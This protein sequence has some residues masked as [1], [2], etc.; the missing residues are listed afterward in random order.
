MNQYTKKRKMNI[1]NRAMVWAGKTLIMYAFNR[2][3][4]GRAVAKLM[5]EAYDV[6]FDEGY[7]VRKKETN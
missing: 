2:D 5:Y 7:S 6:G 4:L 1:K 3:K